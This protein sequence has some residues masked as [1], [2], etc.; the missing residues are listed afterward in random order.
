MAQTFP[1]E[2]NRRE[3]SFRRSTASPRRPQQPHERLVALGVAASTARALVSEY[4]S[5]RV[6]DALD[7]VDTLGDG[8]V[9]RRA[10]WVVAAVREGWNLGE[11]LAERRASEARYAR[12]ERERADRDREAAGWEARQAVADRWRGAISA[13]LDDR[14]LELAI[15]RVTTPAA[16]LGRRSV[17]VAAA[18]LL[19]WA[20][21]AHRRAPGRALS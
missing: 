7:A 9:R 20:V 17:P 15:E 1:P 8:E 19:A 12:W 13:A 16:G 10:G 18:Q 11:L 4:G 14:Q 2:V 21:A 3:Q 5:D 6:V